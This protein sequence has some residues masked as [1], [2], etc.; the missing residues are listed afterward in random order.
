METITDTTLLKIS[1][2]ICIQEM[3]PEEKTV[4]LSLDTGDFFTCNE[5]TCDFLR[6][7]ETAPKPFR[8]VLDEMLKLY[9]VDPEMLATDLK[10]IAERLLAEKMLFVVP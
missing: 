7:V 6:M 10:E 5:T 9:D 1:P 3:G 8:E 4:I 2:G